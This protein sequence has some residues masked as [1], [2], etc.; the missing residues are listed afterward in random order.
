MA[1]TRK[2][3]ELGNNEAAVFQP[4]HDGAAIYAINT[5]LREHIGI[6]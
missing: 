1:H 6:H 4:G 3:T 5:K 2:H